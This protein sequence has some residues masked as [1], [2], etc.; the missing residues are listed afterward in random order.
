M[1]EIGLIQYLFF[2]V[3]LSQPLL[4]AKTIHKEG[5]VFEIH[6]TI[7]ISPE[8]NQNNFPPGP[9]N[10]FKRVEA[11]SKIEILSLRFPE[12]NLSYSPYYYCR[13][14]DSKEN[15]ICVGWLDS[16]VLIGKK[17]SLKDS[18]FVI[19]LQKQYG[20]ISEVSE[21]AI[22]LASIDSGSLLSP[23]HKDVYFFE[24]LLTELEKRFPHDKEYLGDVLVKA[25]EIT[26]NE[27]ASIKIAEL[28]LALEC[29]SRITSDSVKVS[30]VLVSYAILR[31]KGWSHERAING[32]SDMF[33][34]LMD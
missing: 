7:I 23:N 2:L 24:A 33:R 26:R 9:S 15:L 18:P 16:G 27:G 29:I 19:R 10:G 17:L 4:E 30:E 31:I 32:L 6:D 22:Q 12:D 28:A 25:Q 21:C 8:E 34:E 3:F 1:K 5:D 13:V 11:G 20:Q 14:T